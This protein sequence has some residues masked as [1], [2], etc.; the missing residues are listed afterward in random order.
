MNTKK[1]KPITSEQMQKVLSI[2]YEKALNGLP[3]SKG[4]VDFANEYQSK[5][6]TPEI[7]VNKLVK[8]QI[9][10]CGTSGFITGLGGLI[11]LPVAIPANV[12][13]DMTQLN[14]RIKPFEFI[15]GILC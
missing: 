6:E 7:A 3:T 12:A 10:K 11:T 15:A 4:V 1:M 9:L 8:N 13:S 5:H 2:C 14:L